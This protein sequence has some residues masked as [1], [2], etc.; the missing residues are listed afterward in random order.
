MKG[1]PHLFSI[2]NNLDSLIAA[3]LGFT[4]IQIFSKHSG[5]GI[6][7]D[8]VTYLSAA[9]HMT[10]GKGFLSFDNLPVVDFPFIYPFFLTVISFFTRL[11]PLVFGSWINGILFG[12]LLY[13][14]GGIMNNFYKTNS[15][16][17]RILLCCILLSPAMQEVYSYLWSETIF[18]LLILLFI[19]S[20]SGYIRQ[21][22]R[23]WLI[24]SAG[25]CALACMTR[26]AGVFLLVTGFYIIFFNQGIAWRK[27]IYHC[28]LFGVFSISLILI[29]II[30][31]QVLT[32]LATGTR[33]KSNTGVLRIM[34]Y[35]GG[36]LC[37]WLLVERKPVL[38]TVLTVFVLLLF[39][40][41]IAL[42]RRRNKWEVGFEY[43]M[44][45]TGL[46]YCLF[47]LF[48]SS[49]VRYEQFT[50]RLLAP[51]FIP[52]LWS[53]S[54]WIPSLLSKMPS[55]IKWAPG[56]LFLVLAAWFINIQLAADWEY[57]DGVKDAG[58]PGYR[59]DPFVQSEL[60]QYMEKNKMELDPR[61]QIYSNAGEAVYFISGLPAR[62]L[63]FASFPAKV[64]Q[65]YDLKNNYLIW[66]RDL[67]NPEMP[68]L[69]E[70]LK[71]K[72]MLLLKQLSDGAIYITR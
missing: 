22:K 26:Y 54:W 47:M 43:T 27:R 46:M 35:F 1:K 39:I 10:E 49:L 40:L 23:K 44:A 56:I 34:E 11:D 58:M 61:F 52:C 37:D 29:N 67:D 4:L 16:Y 33:P 24:L 5:I 71:N 66:F 8:S 70:I 50:N 38:A 62:Q 60:V 12:L 13:L 41:T 17:K 63:P 9:R 32:G 51:M 48:T 14:S 65:Y 42:T 55:R 2:S 72:N 19:V 21:T 69:G 6:S 20:I 53:L 45:C 15:W 59:E 28:F 64:R 68:G 57:Y 30:R 25:I 18:L 36:V 3:L 7:P 31:N